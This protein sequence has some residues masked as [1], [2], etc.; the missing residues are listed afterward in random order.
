MT[1]WPEV[2]DS[3]LNGPVVI[4][5]PLLKAVCCHGIGLAFEGVLGQDA[6][7]VRQVRRQGAERPRQIEFHGRRVHG[8]DATH[9]REVA[10]RRWRPDLASG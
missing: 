10:S 2:Y 5:V 9:G 1:L 8:L 6:G 7:V 3:T 4:G